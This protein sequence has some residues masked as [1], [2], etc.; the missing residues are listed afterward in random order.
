MGTENSDELYRGVVRLH[1]DKNEVVIGFLLRNIF[2]HISTARGVG[3]ENCKYNDLTEV[4]KL[5]NF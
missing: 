2:N 3:I 1:Q 4:A 5:F